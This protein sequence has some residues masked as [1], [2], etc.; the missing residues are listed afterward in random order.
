MAFALAIAS[1]IVGFELTSEFSVRTS[2]YLR[3]IS[4]LSGELEGARAER[5]ARDNLN[6][7]L[8]DPNATIIR[9][10]PRMTASPG[11]G[12]I[13][14]SLHSGRAALEVSGLPPLRK[15]HLYVLWWLPT[16][17]API[18]AA[19]FHTD[20]EGRASVVAAMPHPE[21]KISGGIITV[22]SDGSPTAPQGEVKLRGVL[23][24][25]SSALARPSSG[26]R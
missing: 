20:I 8:A 26:R 5:A 9:L 18:K 19:T 1:V 11:S 21:A 24:T 13:A 22:E 17:G 10:S 3:R 14:I 2:R 4:R 15:G 12:L 7:I 23:A 16:H 6:H 25:N